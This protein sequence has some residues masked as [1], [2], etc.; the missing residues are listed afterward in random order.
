MSKF[1]PILG[2]LWFSNKA[3]VLSFA[4]TP[5]LT[6]TVR[7]RIAPRIARSNTFPEN[8]SRGT[9]L[10]LVSF[11][12][13]EGKYTEVYI[14]V[15]ESP[16][17]YSVGGDKK[18]FAVFEGKYTEGLFAVWESSV[19]YSVGGTKKSFA[20]FESKHTVGLFAAWES[21]V[22]YTVGGAKKSFAVFESKHTEGLF[23][24]WESSVIYSVGGTKK[25]FAVFEGK[26]TGSHRGVRDGHREGK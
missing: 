4:L 11:A 24:V 15:D 1:V 20:V 17:I 7:G 10:S 9:D 25:N 13:F 18:S 19:I 23:A 6:K 22:I 8:K 5:P 3:V 12:I 21:S 14:V 26:H 16:V 2:N